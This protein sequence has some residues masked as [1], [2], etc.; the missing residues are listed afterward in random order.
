MTADVDEKV[1]EAAKP[2]EAAAPEMA[3][4]SVEATETA[5]E[6]LLQIGSVAPPLNIPEWVMGKEVDSFEAGKTY[7]VEFWATWCPPCRTSMPHLSKLQEEYGDAV[8]FIGVSDEDRATVDAFF[9]K[10]QDD[11]NTWAEIISYSIAIDP[12]RGTHK[13]YMQAAK[14]QGI[15]TAFVVG[16][17]GFIEWIGHPMEMDDPL[18]Q[19]ASGAW[20]REAARAKQIA[21]AEAQRRLQGAM[22]ELQQAQ[23]D[24]DYDKAIGIIDELMAELPQAGP[25]LGMAK[26]SMLLGAERTEEANTMLGELAEENW[27]NSGF[28]NGLAWSMATEMKGVELADAMKYAERA[29]E[30]ANDQDGSI[31]DTVAR[32]A[33]EIGDLAKAVEWQKKAVAADP[34]MQETLD[35]Y[36]AELAGGS[37]DDD[38]ADEPSDAPVDT[39][40][41]PAE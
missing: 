36:E 35:R 39:A 30:L 20:D 29:N 9:A 12:N 40:D 15:P 24:G 6:E 17:E 26:I 5:Q 18:A 32:V 8:T 22:R 11:E 10:E 19:M 37:E 13:D 33:Y 1:E 7:V 3:A 4:G 23:S 25:R 27:E 21:A 14:Q 16:P 31:L 2:A 34:S 38:A 41:A 28:L